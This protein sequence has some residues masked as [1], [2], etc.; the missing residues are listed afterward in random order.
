MRGGFGGGLRQC[1]H[2]FLDLR[3]ELPD[4]FRVVR[5]RGISERGIAIELF[6]RV[7]DAPACDCPD[8]VGYENSR[9][10][11]QELGQKERQPR[12]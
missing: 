6:G 10:D 8:E 4:P 2:Q 5:R 7:R 11:K 1:G 12:S 9:R 3:S